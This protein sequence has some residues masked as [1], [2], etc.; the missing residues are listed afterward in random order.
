MLTMSG[1]QSWK[2]QPDGEGCPVSV[3][4]EQEIN[5]AGFTGRGKNLVPRATRGLQRDLMRLGG[6]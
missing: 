3:N 6:K 1:N 4:G 5:P 2:T